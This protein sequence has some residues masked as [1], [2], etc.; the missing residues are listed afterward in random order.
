MRI[1]GWPVVVLSRGRVVVADGKLEA[2]RGSGNFLHRERS[3]F[4]A[5][6]RRL[7]PEMDPARNFGAE[8]LA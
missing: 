7:E 6:S 3:E 1:T 8:I 4:A 2:E 5:P